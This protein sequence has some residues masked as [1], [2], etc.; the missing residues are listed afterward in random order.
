[1]IETPHVPERI[2]RLLWQH[3]ILPSRALSTTDGRSVEVL[4]PGTPNDDSGPDF[5][6]ARIRIGGVLYSGSVEIHRDAADWTGH[7]HHEDDRY[8]SVILHVAFSARGADPSHTTSSGRRLP[9]V[10]LGRSPGGGTLPRQIGPYLHSPAGGEHALP[11]SG[12]NEVIPGD[13][14]L[15]WLSRLGTRRLER[16]SSRWGRRLTALLTEARDPGGAHTGAIADATGSGYGP[17]DFVSPVLWDQALYEAFMEGLGY[18]KN[19]QAFRTLAQTVTLASLRRI[20]L[21]NT[22]DVLAVLFG[23]AHLLPAPGA[24]DDPLAQRYAAEVRYRWETLSHAIPSAPIHASD[25]LFFRLRP[26][27]FP[28]A[29]IAAF[30]HALPSIFRPGFR[31]CLDILRS[32]SS[33]ERTMQR[34]RSVLIVRAGGFWRYRTSFDGPPAGGGSAIGRV[35]ATEL[36]VNAVLPLLVRFADTFGDTGLRHTVHGMMSDRF[37]SP[38][39]RLLTR[40]QADLFRGRVA[41]DTPLLYQGAIELYGEYCVRLRCR[42]CAVGAACGFRRRSLTADPGALWR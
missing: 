30:S 29:R 15:G 11:C 25:W 8:N 19:R 41:A 12:V 21:G 4:F 18:A 1:M 39:H 32:G 42:E 10:L 3:T 33:A 28:T 17:S 37:A 26:S 6:D 23:A 13:L 36:I 35:R 24:L 20:G 9:V 14:L 40:L 34:L 31:G 22:G 2:L 27:N 7:G 38:A 5:L 16:K